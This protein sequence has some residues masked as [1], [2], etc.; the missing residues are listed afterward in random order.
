VGNGRILKGGKVVPPEVKPGDQI[1]FGKYAGSEVRHEEM[2][3]LMMHE[4]D[5]LTVLET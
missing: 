1:L 3:L 5:I 2:E 4:T